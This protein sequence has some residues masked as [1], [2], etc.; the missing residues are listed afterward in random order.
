ME[1]ERDRERD[2]RVRR[3][4]E[5]SSIRQIVD[6]LSVERGTLKRAGCAAC[7]R[8]CAALLVDEGD[9]LFRMQRSMMFT[10]MTRRNVLG[11]CVFA[12]R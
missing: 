8:A 5:R 6:S 2:D 7:A 9:I 12:D 10:T 1:K 11:V 4:V 3:H